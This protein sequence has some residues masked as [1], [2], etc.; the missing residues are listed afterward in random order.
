MDIEKPVVRKFVDEWNLNT[1]DY[2]YP[3]RGVLIQCWLNINF[4][5]NS[6]IFSLIFVSKDSIL[7][8]ILQVFHSTFYAVTHLLILQVYMSFSSL[9]HSHTLS[10]I[11][12]RDRIVCHAHFSSILSFSFAQCLKNLLFCNVVAVWRRT[13]G[14]RNHSLFIPQYGWKI[15]S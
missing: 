11:E 14:V 7:A 13:C 12:K 15:N 8:L 9:L 6:K 3:P 10:L 4:C 2:F 1:A 5:F